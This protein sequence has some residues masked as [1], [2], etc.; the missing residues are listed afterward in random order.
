MR[1]RGEGCKERR[2]HQGS[3]PRRGGAAACQGGGR[4]DDGEG[5][6]GSQRPAIPGQGRRCKQD[7]GSRFIWQYSAWCSR[8]SRKR[9]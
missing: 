9:E 1:S 6:E 8:S 7:G 5:R 3:V 4:E 2:S